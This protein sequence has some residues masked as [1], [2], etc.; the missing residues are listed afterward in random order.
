ADGSGLSRD[1]RVPPDTMTAWLRS[2]FNDSDLREPLFASLATPGEGT[3]TNR[4]RDMTL[5]N[6]VRGKSGSLT[7][8]R[9]LSGVM[10]HPVTGRSLVFSIFVNQGDKGVVAVNAR[11]FADRA[12]GVLDR[13]LTEEE[14]VDAFGG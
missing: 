7:G 5:R 10:T 14:S 11:D 8:V 1:N 3:F 9:T 12:V 2:F 13:W 4:F 6:Q